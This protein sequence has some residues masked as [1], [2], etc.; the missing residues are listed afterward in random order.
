MIREE[1]IDNN[2]VNTKI[3]LIWVVFIATKPATDDAFDREVTFK[4]V[5]CEQK[6]G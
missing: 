2:Q 6:L 4:K 1:K 5:T 3:I